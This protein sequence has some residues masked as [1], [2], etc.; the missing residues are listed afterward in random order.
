MMIIGIKVKQNST[1]RIGKILGVENYDGTGDGRV[2]IKFED[3]LEEKKFQFPGS[4]FGFFSF[5]SEEDK[6]NAISYVEEKKSAAKA[7]AEA[8]AVAKAEAEAK[9][10]AE[11]K[12]KEEEA[13]A[14]KTVVAVADRTTAAELKKILRDNGCCVDNSI[15][16]RYASI[17][18]TG[19]VYW[20]TP[21][22]KDVKGT[23]YLALRDQINKIVRLFLIDT[24]KPGA[25][26]DMKSLAF[27]SDDPDVNHI[28]IIVNDPKFTDRMS[29][30]EFKPYLIEEV[31]Y[32]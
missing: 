22:A 15:P 20:L 8:D 6:A 7:K 21:S 28:E 19:E 32:F 1:G 11:Q 12:A 4:F 14:K 25:L 13:K 30:V 5:E 27:K 16:F 2:I 26:Y 24:T 23:W 29:N 31:K 18:K 17:N 9:E 3:N 10:K